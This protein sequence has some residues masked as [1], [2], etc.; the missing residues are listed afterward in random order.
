MNSESSIRKPNVFDSIDN[1]L[2]NTHSLINELDNSLWMMCELF[3]IRSINF[4]QDWCEESVKE[5]PQSKIHLLYDKIGAINERLSYMVK[6]S[7]NIRMKI[8]S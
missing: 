3:W 5:T 8:D 1:S 7:N 6:Y 2:S 4:D